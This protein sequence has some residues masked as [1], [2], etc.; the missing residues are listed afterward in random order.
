MLLDN[1]LERKKGRFFKI[2]IWLN[3]AFIIGAAA[4]MGVYYFCNATIGTIVIIA[5]MVLKFIECILRLIR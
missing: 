5:A 3:I 1:N 4:G 2:R